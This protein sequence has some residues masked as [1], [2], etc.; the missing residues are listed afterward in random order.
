M[1]IQHLSVDE[2]Y[3]SL[4]TAPDGLAVEEARTRLAEYGP[5]RIEA[6]APPSTLRLLL[7]QFTHFFALIL[8]AAAA[9]AFAADRQQPGS[10]M[11]A[12]GAAIIGVIAVNGAFS[13]WQE[14]RAE[15]ALAAL[16]RLLPSRATVVRD[17]RPSVIEAAAIVPGDVLI[18]E[19]GNEVPA[20]CRLVEAFAV[21]VNAATVT[22]ESLPVARGAEPD[23]GEDPLHGRNLLLAGTW[24]VS[25]QGRAVVFATGMRTEFG[26]IAGLTQRTAEPPSP[27]Q[28]QIAHLSRVIALVAL[29][30]GGI[31]FAIGRMLDL[32]FWDTFLF[33]IGIIVANVPEGLLPTVTLSMAMASQRMARRRTLVR[34]LPAVETLGSA[35]VICTD[36][37]GT[38][39]ENRMQVVRVFVAGAEHAA[40]RPGAFAAHAAPLLACARWC[41]HVR[42][43]GA[44]RPGGGG[45][46]SGAEPSRWLGDPM[47]VALVTFASALLPDAPAAKQIGEVPFDAE[48]KRMSTLHD[49]GHGLML[50]TKGAPETVLPLCTSVETAS[51]PAAAAGEAL[52]PVTEAHARMASMGLRVL[53]LAWRQVGAE[54]RTGALEE[55]LTLAGLVGIEDPP[56][57]EVADA[58]ERCRTAGIRVIMITGD[59][60][61]TAMAIARQI[62]LVRTPRPVVVRG[63]HVAR[64]AE[65]Q[66]Q[67]VLDAPEVHFARAAADHKMRIVQALQR[68]GHVVA[69]TGDGVNDAPALRAADVGIAMGLSGTDVAREASDIVLLDDNF[70]SIV[71]AVEEGR[72]VWDNIRRFLTYILT[73]NVPELIPYLAFVLLRVPL[74]LT[75]LQILA[76]DLGTDMVPALGLGAER[77]REHV[78]RRPPRPKGRRLLDAG[79]LTRAYL[80]LG[81]LEAAGSI[82]VFFSVLAAG[83]WEWGEL[84]EAADPLY[85][86]ATTAC[87]TTVVCMQVANVFLCRSARESAAAFPPFGNPLIVAGIVVELALML[88]IA[89][90]PAGNAVF[91]TA[92]V[93]ASVWLMAGAAAVSMLA[94]EE[95][96]K[97][98][99]R[100]R[101]FRRRIEEV[102]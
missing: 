14:Y 77:P 34:H 89:Y 40:D 84:P 100:A 88:F 90:T 78:M 91:A 5:N 47:E 73:S 65:A 46:R 3:A 87:L 28:Q 2:V 12:L 17:G 80:F 75:I 13:F 69:V 8:W 52:Q 57:A 55:K 16:R 35:S 50:Y 45:G 29:G 20:D 85:Q 37:T 95:I 86:L 44:P 31:F 19:E 70:A 93:P 39:T 22:G 21:R 99:L 66:L 51:G 1:R 41:N 82:T 10:G 58:I 92:P 59:H 23:P 61:E 7:H 15:R 98:A 33:A 74:A 83:G 56:R 30:I 27:L 76:I 9:L 53:A 101:P 36:K 68:K 64:M 72:A 26:R 25:G 96:R 49:T 94:C 32:P 71:A 81:L 102:I 54:D 97:A 6:I 43:T 62:G 38:L 60:P 24:L 11:A 42:A 4:K 79:L 67:L 18:L 63:E 48:R